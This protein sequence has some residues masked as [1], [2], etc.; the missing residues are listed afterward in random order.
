METKLKVILRFLKSS[1]LI[2]LLSSAF[3]LLPSGSFATSFEDIR[4]FKP[5]I[6]DYRYRLNPHFNKTLRGTTKFIIVHTSECDLE[7]T[8]KIVSEGKQENGRWISRGGHTHYVIARD[9]IIFRI[10]DEKYIASHAG[11]SMWNGITGLNSCSIGIELVGYHNK[12]IT[13]SQYQS[14][15]HLIKKLKIK[16]RLEDR[17]VLTHS[18]VAYSKPNEWFRKNHRGRKFCASNFDRKLAGLSSTWS[19]DPDVKSGRLLPNA[20][21]SMIFYKTE[22]PVQKK[23]TSNIIGPETSAWAIAGKKYD[24]PNTLYRLPNGWVISGNKIASR[25]GWDSIPD[26]TFVYC[27]SN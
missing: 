19:Y 21:L 25:I 26:G 5:S 18:Q 20:M 27:D 15:K 24:G 23:A 6:I 11:L 3:I 17:L 8:L 4:K 1:I 10:L 22:L 13:Q 2:C 9:G 16:Y 14:V 7:M 12:R